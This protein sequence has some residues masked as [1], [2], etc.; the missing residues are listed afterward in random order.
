METM[1]RHATVGPHH[2]GMPGLEAVARWIEAHHERID[3]RG[4]PEMLEGEEI[5]LPAR[6]LA[7]A[8]TYC[9]L[10]SERPYRPAFSAGEALRIIEGGAGPQFDRGVAEM[11]PAA[12][13]EINDSAA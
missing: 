13:R 12:L 5:P 2:Q 10:R 7:V 6:I 8:D 4:Y 1:Q 11:L 9:A 3:E